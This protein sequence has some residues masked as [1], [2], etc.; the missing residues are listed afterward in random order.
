M[1]NGEFY[2]LF[3]MTF[4]IVTDTYQL[5]VNPLIYFAVTSKQSQI[6]DLHYTSFG[7]QRVLILTHVTTFIFLQCSAGVKGPTVNYILKLSNRRSTIVRCYLK[8][9]K[10]RNIE[11]SSACSQLYKRSSSKIVIACHDNP[12]LCQAQLYP[13]NFALLNV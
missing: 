12:S 8:V 11:P 7:H 2:N 6:L 4:S 10:F 5:T 13:A 1:V 9:S 3:L